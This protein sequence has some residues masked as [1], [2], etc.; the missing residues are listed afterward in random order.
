M[1]SKPWVDASPYAMR[2]FWQAQDQWYPTW[3]KAGEMQVSSVKMWQ[4]C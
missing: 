1:G 4:Q 3:D 2:D